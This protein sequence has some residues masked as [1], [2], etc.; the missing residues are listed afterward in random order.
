MARRP[1]DVVIVLGASVSPSG[2]PTATLRCRVAKGVRTFEETGAEALLLTGG[3]AGRKPAEAEVMHDLARHAGVPEDRILIETEAS[4]T[5]ENAR[6]S[7]DIMRRHGWTRAVVVT[8]ALHIP[9]ALLAFLGTGVRVTGRGARL[10]WRVGPF[11]TPFH[12]LV[13]EIA[14]FAWY[15]VRIILRRVPD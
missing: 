13:Y 15:A 11:R 2:G 10:A 3:P 5:F 14:G 4:S 6:R 7:A 12:Y 1:P 8:D 9:R